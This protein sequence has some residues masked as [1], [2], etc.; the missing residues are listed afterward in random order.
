MPTYDFA[1]KACGNKF[2]M[3]VI[4]GKTPAPQCPACGHEEV[5]R[6]ITGSMVKTEGTREIAM[7][8]ARRREANRGEERVQEQLRYEREHEG[9]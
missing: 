5:E 2:E 3:L 9:H 6:L 4:P 1:C 8:A 7:R